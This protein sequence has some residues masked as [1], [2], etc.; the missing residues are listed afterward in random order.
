MFD[1]AHKMRIR[2]ADVVAANRIAAGEFGRAFLLLAVG[3][4]FLAVEN[5]KTRLELVSV[6]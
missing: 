2:E 1:T 3:S 4:D 6:K 5:A